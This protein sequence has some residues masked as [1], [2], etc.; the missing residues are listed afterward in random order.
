MR[1]MRGG[2]LDGAYTS[3][4]KKN[5]CPLRD[6]REAVSRKLTGS[7]EALDVPGIDVIMDC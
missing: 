4:F 7:R 5:N 1:A 2:E 6:G 3:R